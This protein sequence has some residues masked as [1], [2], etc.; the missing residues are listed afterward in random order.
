MK[1]LRRSF[2]RISQEIYKLHSPRIKEEIPKNIQEET[3]EEVALESLDKSQKILL[4]VE[5]PDMVGE[6]TSN[7]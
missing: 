6:T 5:S 1:N 7:S 3:L 2:L 4:V